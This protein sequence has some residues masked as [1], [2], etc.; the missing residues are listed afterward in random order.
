MKE[1]INAEHEELRNHLEEAERENEEKQ[2][3]LEELD[4][5]KAEMIKKYEH[6]IQNLKDHSKVVKMGQDT[7]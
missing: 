7:V 6:Q 3:E 4:L 5:K 1:S 2:K